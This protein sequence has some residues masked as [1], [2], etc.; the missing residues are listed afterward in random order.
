MGL[1]QP[2][3]LSSCHQPINL[4]TPRIPGG[5]NDKTTG[6]QWASTCGVCLS[7]SALYKQR[8]FTVLDFILVGERSLPDFQWAL[9]FFF[10]F[11]LVLYFICD[12][13]LFN[14]ACAIISQGNNQSVCDID[15]RH[16][17]RGMQMYIDK[18]LRADLRAV[19]LSQ[20]RKRMLVQPCF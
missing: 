6:V 13:F 11:L 3:S 14:E 15:Y 18:S 8:T 17:I 5:P 16:L 7:L 1:I 12:L 19:H 4:T 2:P 10:F 9:T 20:Q